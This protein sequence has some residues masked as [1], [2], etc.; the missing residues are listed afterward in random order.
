M[1]SWIP[2]LVVLLAAPWA[3]APGA[4]A[5]PSPTGYEHY[6]YAVGGHV[7][8]QAR[9]FDGVGS[10]KFSFLMF[11]GQS[12]AAGD[13]IVAGAR[14]TEWRGTFTQVAVKARTEDN[15]I[16]AFLILQGFAA[17]VPPTATGARTGPGFQFDALGGPGAFRGILTVCDHPDGYGAVDFE[18]GL[19]DMPLAHLPAYLGVVQITEGA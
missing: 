9:Y 13:R 4:L 8:V 11:Q 2:A 7:H 1:K 19:G 18:G 12:G 5:E 10:T 6:A 17:A 16:D 3:M 15:A 14:C